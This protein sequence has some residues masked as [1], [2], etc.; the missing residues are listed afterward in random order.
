MGN[1]RTSH[2]CCRVGSDGFCN[3]FYGSEREG[4]AGVSLI[5][6]PLVL[7]LGQVFP[8]CLS[9]VQWKYLATPGSAALFQ[10]KA[11][12]FQM[13]CKHRVRIGHQGKGQG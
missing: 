12:G 10:V 6:V 1:K 4:K 13:G 9:Q 2:C 3:G 8:F 7:S 5:T 11:R